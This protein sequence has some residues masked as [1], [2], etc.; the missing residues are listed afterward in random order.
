MASNPHRNAVLR[1]EPPKKMPRAI[2]KR[3][4][5][6][7]VEYLVVPPGK[8]NDKAVWKKSKD[9]SWDEKDAC[10]TYREKTGESE[11]RRKGLAEIQMMKEAAKRYANAAAGGHSQKIDQ[12]ERQYSLSSDLAKY[13]AEPINEA[14][15]W[16]DYEVNDWGK[17]KHEVDIYK[18]TPLIKAIRCH[19]LDAVLALLGSGLADPTLQMS[20]MHFIDNSYTM[21]ESYKEDAMS[22][23]RQA[24]R[25]IQWRELAKK[26]KVYMKTNVKN[27][28]ANQ[29]TK[30]AQQIH[31][32]TKI[33]AL[34]EVASSMWPDAKYKSPVRDCSKERG[35]HTNRMYGV[36]DA[37]SQKA[38][39]RSLRKE[40]NSALENCLLEP[41]DEA[42]IAAIIMRNN[43][44]YHEEDHGKKT[45]AESSDDY[46]SSNDEYSSD[47]YS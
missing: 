12:I 46:S 45:A 40:L 6:R 7:Y 4:K 1:R 24:E 3:R 5:G 47:Y 34:V 42:A 15:T 8:K 37:E 28:A 29:A 32:A 22:V 44:M 26:S 10:R 33:V 21:P 19:N 11:K 39:T 9:M 16:R 25:D 38:A 14:E 36:T 18:D 27:F 30:I 17:V 2:D 20:S 35:K 23:A 41:I 13:L 43:A 31:N